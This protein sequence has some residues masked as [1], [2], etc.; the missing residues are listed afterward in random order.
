MGP[1]RPTIELP[2]SRPGFELFFSLRVVSLLV[3]LSVVVNHIQICCCKGRPF[4]HAVVLRL[5]VAAIGTRE[6]ARRPVDPT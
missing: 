6:L 3:R 5:R 2:A 4:A 1:G